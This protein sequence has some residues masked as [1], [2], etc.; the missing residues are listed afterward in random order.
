M[1]FFMLKLDEFF[2][3]VLALE[4]LFLLLVELVGVFGEEFLLEVFF[5]WVG[6]FG[7]GIGGFLL[8]V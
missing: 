5:E 8:R 1:L 7:W 3:L 6:F 4:F 2:E